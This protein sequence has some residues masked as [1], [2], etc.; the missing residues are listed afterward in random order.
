MGTGRLLKER[1]PQEVA[2]IVVPLGRA[3][4]MGSSVDVRSIPDASD[5][6]TK[7]FVDPVSVHAIFV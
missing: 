3:T 1:K 2:R 5:W 7:M 6:R 4:E